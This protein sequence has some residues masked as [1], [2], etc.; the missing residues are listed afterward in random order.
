[1]SGM[2][3]MLAAAL[4]VAGMAGTPD[5]AMARGPRG[6]SATTRP[7]GPRALF[8]RIVSATVDLGDP[9]KGTIVVES[10]RRGQVTVQTDASTV[11]TIDKQAAKVADLKA[12]MRVRITPA[13]GTAKKVSVWTKR[14]VRAGAKNRP[15]PAGVKA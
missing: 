4:V 15:A 5:A 10:R 8:G 12:G 13:T 7:A 14:P 3:K 2:V 11:V 6:R 9:T 1:M